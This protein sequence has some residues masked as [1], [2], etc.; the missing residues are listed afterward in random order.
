MARIK[1]TSNRVIDSNGIA[2]GASIYVYQSGGTTPISIFSDDA[3]AVAVANPYVV[4]SGAA[5]P[6]LYYSYTGDIRVKVVNDGGDTVSDEDPF[7]DDAAAVS[8]RLSFATPAAL[9]ASS[10]ASA[11]T[12]SIWRAGSYTYIE[13]ASGGLLTTAA[14]V[15]LNPVRDSLGFYS[16]AQLDWTDG[17]TVD[18]ELTALVA[19]LVAGDKLEISGNYVTSLDSLALPDNFEM[20][21]RKY[22]VGGFTR[23]GH[24]TSALLIYG[25][26]SKFFGIKCA[27]ASWA[28][29][30]STAD[31]NGFTCSFGSATSLAKAPELYHCDFRGRGYIN[32]IN[33]S[34]N[35]LAQD[36]YFEGG[37]WMNRFAGVSHY[38]R[39][40]R[41]EAVGGYRDS[42]Q[43]DFCKTALS[44]DNGP[45]GGRLIDCVIKTKRNALDTT[46][47]CL[48]WTV[49]NTYMEISDD[50]ALDIKASYDTAVEEQAVVTAGTGLNKRLKVIGCTFVNCTA[51]TTTGN[52]DYAD[53]GTGIGNKDLSTEDRFDASCVSDIELID[54]TFVSD[55]AANYIACSN[56]G[57]RRIKITNPQFIGT[58]DIYLDELHIGAQAATATAYGSDGFRPTDI[59]ISGITY[60]GE[61]RTTYAI[62]AN[63]FTIHAL[64]AEIV[65][66][67]AA[68][69]MFAPNGSSGFTIK[70]KWTI[71]S[72][73]TGEMSLLDWD[74]DADDTA[75]VDVRFESVSAT[76]GELVNVGASTSARTLTLKNC[77][78]IN[79][80]NF[81]QCENAGT[82]ASIR[83]VGGEYRGGTRV[84]EFGTS[85]HTNFFVRDLV[86]TAAV[87]AQYTGTLPTNQNI[88]EY[89][90][91]P[92]LESGDVFTVATVPDAGLAG[93]GFVIHV[94]DETG[95]TNAFSDATN[96]RRYS[97][98][99]VVS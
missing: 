89:N 6:I 63:N 86:T 21:A 8:S 23:S 2:D 50:E 68:K 62:Y 1:Y 32:Q 95:G 60:Y 43:G 39:F 11:G 87:A 64:D 51:L 59:E 19:F 14:S 33:D 78:G 40:I 47:G 88:A 82:S 10:L 45:I 57:Q 41:C 52:F 90:V 97:D 91:L 38:P 70:G 29:W 75:M 66:T 85:A 20:H 9:V 81:V 83:I 56:Y 69:K 48:D 77:V 94:S 15:S 72:T 96:W 80:K 44:S 3:Y 7:D 13:V 99:A 49:T 54:C 53:T 74:S 30:A 46:G 24:G 5:V 28:G 16:T 65:D 67:T 31:T 22:K 4:A 42:L 61:W 58:W 17:A 55:A 76:E 98:R 37:Q 84:A 34:P 27:P 12:G 18:T 71:S 92:D 93:A 73:A 35:F 36:C 26:S 25:E 79:L